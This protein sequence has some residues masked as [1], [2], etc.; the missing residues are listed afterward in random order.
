M[1][2]YTRRKLGQILPARAYFSFPCK[3]SNRLIRV[4]EPKLVNAEPSTFSKPLS[5]V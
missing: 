4:V 2:C 3:H 5:C 1:Q